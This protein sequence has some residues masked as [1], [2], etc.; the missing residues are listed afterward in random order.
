MDNLFECFKA[1]RNMVEDKEN[2][3]LKIT[4]NG[5][6]LEIVVPQIASYPEPSDFET[7]Y[8]VKKTSSGKY[9]VKINVVIAVDVIN[10]SSKNPGLT[11]WNDVMRMSSYLPL[12]IDISKEEFINKINSAASEL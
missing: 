1:T 11:I 4:R 8:Y 7:I 3:E 12:A 2:L 5:D 6:E 10:G 9:R